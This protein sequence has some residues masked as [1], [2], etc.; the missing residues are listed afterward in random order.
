M[1]EKIISWRAPILLSVVCL[2]VFGLMTYRDLPRE[3]YPDIDIPTVMVST[4]YVGVA[5]EDVEKLVTI[6]VENELA[7]LT[8]LKKMSSTSAEGVSLVV[9]EFEP[10]V[11]IED[12]LQRVRDRIARARPKLPADVEET[13]VQEI[14]FDQWPIMIVAISGPTD[15]ERLKRLGE[16]LEDEVKRI[17]GVLDAKLSGGR[18]REISV[19]VD[20]VRLSH[21]KLSL[22]DVLGAISNENV[23]IPGGDVTAGKANFLVRVPGDFTVA[24]DIEKVAIK[25]V[26]DSPV[27]VSDV[28][29]VIDGYED[30]QSYAR[31]NGESAVTLAITKR[32]GA[33]ILDVAKEVKATVGRQQKDW[34]KG[35]VWRVV[36]DQSKEIEMMVS[37]LENNIITAIILV[38]GV[39]F[40]FMGARNSLLVAI[41]LPLTMFMTLIVIDWFGMTLNMVVLFS[42]VFALGNM[43]DNG[44]VLI[45]NIYRHAE[46][47]KNFWDASVDGSKEL[48]MP[49][50]ASA[51]TASAA[52]FPL[53]FWNGIM[54]EFMVFLPKTVITALA[55]SLVVA[56][57]VL[58][59][60][61]VKYMKLSPKKPSADGTVTAFADKPFMRRYR[62]VLEWSIDHR[63]KSLALGAGTFVLTVVAFVLFNNGT[64]FFPEIEPDRAVVGVRAPDGTD[65]EAT[66]AIVRQVEQILIGERNINFFVAETGIAGG[67]DPL[68]GTQA[69]ANQARITVDFLP[70][71][72]RATDDD[73]PRY[74]NTELTI[75]R[76]RAKLAELTGA[77]VEIEKERQGPPVGA[78]ISVE[79]S[80]KEF[81]ELGTAAGKLR[82]ELAG[83]P[84]VADL[85]DNYRVGRP[86]MRLRIDRGAAK[87]VGAS[88]RSVASAVRTAINGAKASVIREGE[89]E[90]DIVV[91]LGEA[92]RRDLQSVMALRIPGREDTSPDTYSVPLSSVASYELA[93]G[94]G[95]IR[96]VD[97]DRIVTIAGD[98][99]EGFNPNSV[100]AAVA[101]Y[102]ESVKMPEGY[103]ARLGGASDEQK[104]S[105]EFLGRAFLMA[106]FLIV[107]VLVAEFNRFDLPIL[108]MATVALSWI[109]VMW[110]LILTQKPFGVIM[111]GIGV[112][113]LAGVVVNNAIVL[114]EYVEQLRGEGRELKDALVTAGVTRFRP[115]MLSA[116]TNV[117][118]V[119]PM[120]FGL[121][122][123]F[124]EGRVVMGGASAE[125]WGPMAVATVFG[126]TFATALTLVM[127]PTMY[128]VFEDFRFLRARIFKGGLFSR[129]P[130]TEA[131]AE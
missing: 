61:T 103:F 83:V 12:K 91:E 102:L 16:R 64:E 71:E 118:G 37:D 129:G 11:I 123:D 74:E 73:V 60:F 29:T 47:G 51:A 126:L 122:I 57:V 78:P 14:S 4:P 34:P 36:G 72:T 70:H 19:A 80:G 43:V 67:G 130:A 5:P 53:V 8:D 35:V 117:L 55:A 56:L 109:G 54:G 124:L 3:S 115:V 116:A 84:G 106:L 24:R 107:L 6:P 10:D 21:Y 87:R 46:E 100:Q 104:E 97:Q 15:E 50:I 18:E 22:D 77:E 105:E 98:I 45:E 90:I 38:V 40:F 48:A 42:L 69:V 13:S 88:T 99:S 125:W 30:R 101:K 89:K 32:S 82:R 127:L 94:S 66:D 1:F 85:S 128:S 68:A 81:H 114:L 96:H 2:T 7:G 31:V 111:T 65:L 17:S 76:V 59:V 27:F 33:N 44:I 75:E 79:I 86:E 39:V 62:Q 9:L 131:A 121:S 120:A 108:I 92:H 20:P 28:A 23:N 113:S 26:G 95:S 93:G 119:L 41:T 25:R 52:L 58:P 110:G 63:Y 112:I 49:L